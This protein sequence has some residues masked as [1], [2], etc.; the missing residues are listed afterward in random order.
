M[1][2]VRQRRPSEKVNEHKDTRSF[3][4]R[5]D[6]EVSLELNFGIAERKEHRLKPVP[7]KTE[8]PQLEPGRSLQQ[9]YC[10]TTV[11]RVKLKN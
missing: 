11:M 6:I 3:A 4:L 7:P 9:G 2:G 10:T 8:T 1:R 5:E